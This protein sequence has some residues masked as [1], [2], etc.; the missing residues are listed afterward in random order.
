MKVDKIKTTA[1]DPGH[2]KFKDTEYDLGSTKNYCITISMQKIS[3]ICHF[4]LEIQ[5]ILESHDRKDDVHL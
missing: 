4:I 1:V 2:L 5:Q 3:S